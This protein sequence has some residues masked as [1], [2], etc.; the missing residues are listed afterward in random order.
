[1]NAVTKNNI[2]A[3][4]AGEV[5]RPTG[6]SESVV[7][8]VALNSYS[9]SAETEELASLS[10]LQAEADTEYGAKANELE[11]A[12]RKQ[13]S[14]EQ[15]VTLTDLPDTEPMKAELVEQNKGN[16]REW[17][18]ADQ[19]LC[20]LY[21]FFWFA[22]ACFS[23][24]TMAAIVEVQDIAFIEGHQYRVYLMSSMPLFA[25]IIVER[26]LVRLPRARRV[27][28][29]DQLMFFG[30]S[31]MLIWLG[32]LVFSSG[33]FVGGGWSDFVDEIA[34][35]KPVNGFADIRAYIAFLQVLGEITLIATL[36]ER[37][38]REYLPRIEVENPEY[39]RTEA[40]VQKLEGEL[41]EIQGRRAETEAKIQRALRGRDSFRKRAEA[42]AEGAVGVFREVLGLM[43]VMLR[44][45]EAKLQQARVSVREKRRQ[46]RAQKR[47]VERLDRKWRWRYRHCL[48]EVSEENPLEKVFREGQKVPKKVQVCYSID[49][50][51]LEKDLKKA[52]ELLAQ[53]SVQLE[54]ASEELS[55]LVNQAEEKIE[56]QVRHEI[57]ERV[58]K[59]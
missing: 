51:R 11:Q 52:K 17:S 56:K 22:F 32:L 50:T 5:M 15:I 48:N 18:I 57:E 27:K 45:H 16:S 2:V 31:A 19:V 33:G 47:E 43:K 30:F 59:L 8:K 46:E 26:W 29:S 20:S 39:T 24:V 1:M 35:P 9:D 54:Q 36:A 25:G 42:F 41:K 49:R 10:R 14:T 28:R 23:V 3:S 53:R 13:N 37:I 4:I 6:Q 58:L 38:E 44:D 7:R 12:R 40:Q 55:K 34:K 21:T